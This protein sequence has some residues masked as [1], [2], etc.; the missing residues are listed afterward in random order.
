MNNQ[1]WFAPFRL[2][3][4]RKYGLCFETMQFFFYPFQSIQ[5]ILKYFVTGRTPTTSNSLYVYAQDF[6]L[7][8][9]CNR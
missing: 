8:G 7:D 6:H 4:F 9:L 2:G 1:K 5:L 3:S